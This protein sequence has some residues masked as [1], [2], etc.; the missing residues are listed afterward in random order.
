MMYELIPLVKCD[1]GDASR[2]YRETLVFHKGEPCMFLEKDGS[3]AQ[4][5]GA[6]GNIIAV[7][8]TD[9]RTTILEPFY[10]ASTGDYVGHQAGRRTSRGINYPRNQYGDVVSMLNT[11]DVPQHVYSNGV[12]LN[13]D[14][15]TFIRKGVHYLLYRTEPVGI[16]ED[17]VYYVSDIF[18]K[19]RLEKINGTISV[20]VIEE[21]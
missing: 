16:C 17:N 20:R 9:L 2:Y 19:E 15:R 12:R 8:Y 3:R 13:K 18:I 11:G 10:C 7:N 14:F 1:R 21:S 4:V 5:M 6:N